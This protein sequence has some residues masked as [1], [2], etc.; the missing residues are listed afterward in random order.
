MVYPCSLNVCTLLC[1]H[2]NG[3]EADTVLV[4]TRCTVGT[5]FATDTASSSPGSGGSVC[6]D[7]PSAAS[8]VLQARGCFSVFSLCVNDSDNLAVNFFEDP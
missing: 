3:V 7:C 2:E 8:H 6:C 1:F 5:I 4:P